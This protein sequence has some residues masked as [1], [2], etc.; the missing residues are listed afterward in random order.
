MELPDYTPSGELIK[1]SDVEDKEFFL[2]FEVDPNTQKIQG[3][4]LIRVSSESFRI[5]DP[6]KSI[7][8]L[9][10]RD[11]PTVNFLLVPIKVEPFGLVRVECFNYSAKRF[12]IGSLILMNEIL[13]N[14]G[15]L[16]THWQISSW[17]H[18]TFAKTV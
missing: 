18:P 7:K 16:N 8:V 2:E 6:E 14:Q 3:E 13:S 12:V 4:L 5:D 1:K 11:S 17:E 9:P 15:E 10:D